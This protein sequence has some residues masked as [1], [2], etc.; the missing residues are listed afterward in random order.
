MTEAIT[1]ACKK[2]IGS[3]N[4]AIMNVEEPETMYLVKNS[5]EMAIG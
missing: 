3:Y 5:G 2:L 4:L 1:A